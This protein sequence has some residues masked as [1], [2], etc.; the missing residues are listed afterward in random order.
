MQVQVSSFGCWL[1]MQFDISETPFGS[2]VVSIR[3]GNEISDTEL[4]THIV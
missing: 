4:Q 1:I 3:D 2:R